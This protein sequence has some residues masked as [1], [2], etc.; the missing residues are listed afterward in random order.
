MATKAQVKARYRAAGIMAPSSSL[1]GEALQ[2]HIQRRPAIFA[3]RR[4][5][6]NRSRSAQRAR[7]IREAY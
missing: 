6:R 1:E 7:A 3:D 4:T 2:A 5:R